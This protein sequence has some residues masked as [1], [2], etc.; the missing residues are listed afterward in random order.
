MPATS[1]PEP[2][3]A[4]SA[5]VARRAP[6]P[7]GRSAEPRHQASEQQDPQVAAAEHQDD[8]R[9]DREHQHR[10]HDHATSDAVGERTD[11]QERGDQPQGVG[12]EQSG[13]RLAGEV[14]LAAVHQQHGRELVGA[15][16]DRE[17][18]G[19][20]AEPR[21]QAGCHPVTLGSVPVLT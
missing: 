12:A 13:D 1:G 11:D 7:P 15:P 5:S 14:V 21:R 10:P 16:A 18:R 3:P 17:H 2:K 19:G 6:V 8:R 9:D 20:D 4:D